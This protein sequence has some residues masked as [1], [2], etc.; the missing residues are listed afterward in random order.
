MRELVATLRAEKKVAGNKRRAASMVASHASRKMRRL[1]ASKSAGEGGAAAAGAAAAGA[2]AG[3]GA[4]AN[5][6]DAIELPDDEGELEVI[7]REAWPE[8]VAR[9]EALGS[10]RTIDE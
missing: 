8:L 6:S 5:A 2:G 1:L 3:A 9:A 7:D 10:W 4:G